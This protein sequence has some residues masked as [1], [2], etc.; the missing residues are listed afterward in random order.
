MSLPHERAFLAGRIRL[1]A[2]DIN[3]LVELAQ[4]LHLFH[5]AS[6]L[7][8]INL[9]LLQVRTDVLETLAYRPP[10]AP[11]FPPRRPD[12]QDELPF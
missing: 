7:L 5:P 9:E 10:A 11:Q 2:L 12:C 1:V 8:D 6:Q 3:Q 4:D